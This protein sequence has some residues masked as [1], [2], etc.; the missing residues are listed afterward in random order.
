MNTSRTKDYANR[1]WL[2]TA[3]H[4]PVIRL[5]KDEHMVKPYVVRDIGNTPPYTLSRHKSDL[6]QDSN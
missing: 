1:A 3:T 6:E 5:F 4:K 2:T